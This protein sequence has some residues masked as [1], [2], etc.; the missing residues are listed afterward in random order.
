MLLLIALFQLLTYCAVLCLKLLE[1]MGT[2][3]FNSRVQVEAFHTFPSVQ[4]LWWI[5]LVVTLLSFCSPGKKYLMSFLKGLTPSL[6]SSSVT[7]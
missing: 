2:F 3:L 1:K 5:G 4:Y 7:F 6:S